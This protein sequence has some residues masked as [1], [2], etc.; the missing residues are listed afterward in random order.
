MTYPPQPGQEGHL[1]GGF[2]PGGAEIGNGHQAY[3]TGPTPEQPNQ[4]PFAPP[5]DPPVVGYPTQFYAPPPGPG[6]PTPGYGYGA[7]YGYLGQYP[8]SPGTDGLAIASL[9][10]SCLAT[11][12]LCAWGIGGLPF[13]ITGA[14]LGHVAKRRIRT[15]RASGDGL[16]LAGII[17]GWTAVGLGLLIVATLAFFIISDQSTR[18]Y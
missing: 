15:S 8:A 9:V 5:A 14:I 1:P 10:L 3:W 13:G 2:G 17:V 4:N 7:P 11:V 6:Y 12:S 16:A 18:N